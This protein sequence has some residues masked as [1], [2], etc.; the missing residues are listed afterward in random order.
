MA[1][2][3]PTNHEPESPRGGV[4]GGSSLRPDQPVSDEGK[5]SELALEAARLHREAS[6]ALAAGDLATARDRFLA[7]A[8]NRQA[9]GDRA[10]EAVAWYQLASIAV[11]ES[12]SAAA[13]ASFRKTLELA[14][15]V[16]DRDV[17]AAA[18]HQVGLIA[19]NK[20]KRATGLLLVAISFGLLPP[21]AGGDEEKATNLLAHMA[22]AMGYGSDRLQTVLSESVAE[23][24]HDGGRSL[25]EEALSDAP[26][27]T[28]SVFESI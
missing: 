10:R 22:A 2:P 18:L 8:K 3:V 5:R 15:A 28:S 12:D 9:L 4:P 16:G 13:A 19:W 14:R 24:E 1:T 17:E 27:S 11:R 20:G 23:Y 7:A 25:V 26:E 6:A 21:Q